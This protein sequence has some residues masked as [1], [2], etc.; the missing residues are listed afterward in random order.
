FPFLT[1]QSGASELLCQ[2]RTKCNPSKPFLQPHPP[3][4]NH[5]VSH[6][7][8]VGLFNII[9]KE[10][11]T[12]CSASIQDFTVGKQNVSCCSTDNC[13]RNGVGSVASSYAMMAAGLSATLLCTLLRNGL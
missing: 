12:S 3:Q 1:L 6:P 11:T 10:C 9:N 4:G 13:N 5:F 7:G 8:I 2:R